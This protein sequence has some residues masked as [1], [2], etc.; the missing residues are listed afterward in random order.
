MAASSNVPQ[1]QVTE[2]D[3]NRLADEWEAQVTRLIENNDRV[4]WDNAQ[5]ELYDGLVSSGFH[6]CITHSSFLFAVTRYS[7]A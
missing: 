2:A 3:A 1:L 5:R 6:L 7:G 4:A